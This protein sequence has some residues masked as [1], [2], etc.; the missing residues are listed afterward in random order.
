MKMSI[1]TLPKMFLAA[2]AALV[3]VPAASAL[4][5]T[6][7]AHSS[8]KQ[9][10]GRPSFLT[11]EA[12]QQPFS[13]LDKLKAKRL[14]LRRT[15]EPEVEAT[16]ESHDLEDVTNN[17]LMAGLEYLYEA[18]EERH[19]DDLFHIILMPSTFH[20]D[21]MSIENTA[22]SCTEILGIPSDKAQDLSL[23][24]KHQGFSCLGT[25]TREECLSIG[26]ELLS[27]DLD[28]RIIPFNGGGVIPKSV[29]ESSVAAMDVSVQI[30][31]VENTYLL[32]LGS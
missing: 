26:E 25:W 8:H 19:S 1:I 17:S 31:V 3:A 11:L 30:A 27:R 22:Q 29:P 20:K 24:A 21:H 15:P 12:K 28:C 18:G 14:S 23:F 6:Y 10:F 7:N 32:S 9:L 13:E 16:V 4:L 2:T 5:S